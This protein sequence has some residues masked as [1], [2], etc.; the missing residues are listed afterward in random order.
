MMMNKGKSLYLQT[1]KAKFFF[2]PPNALWVGESSR[3][4]EWPPPPKP[5]CEPPQQNVGQ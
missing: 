5:I 2:K 1:E 3:T 4:N